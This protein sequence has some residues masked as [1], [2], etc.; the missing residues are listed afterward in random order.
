MKR[1]GYVALAVAGGVVV[2]GGAGALRGP[3]WAAAGM[4]AGPV[5]GLAAVAVVWGLTTPDPA[6]LLQAG[7]HREAPRLVEEQLPAWRLAARIW[8]GQ[9]RDALAVQLMNKSMALLAVHWHAV[10]GTT[11]PSWLTTDDDTPA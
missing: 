10:T 9:F 7:G 4:V 2:L 3:A 5:V 11:P 1:P 6:D 8:P